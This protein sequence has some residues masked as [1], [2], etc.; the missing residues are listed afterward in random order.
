MVRKKI[1]QTMRYAKLSPENGKN[2]VVGL[3]K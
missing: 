2:A 1:V 3:Y